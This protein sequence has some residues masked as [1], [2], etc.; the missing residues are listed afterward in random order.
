MLTSFKVAEEARKRWLQI[1]R[2]QKWIEELSKDKKRTPI[3]TVWLRILCLESGNIVREEDS[4][5]LVTASTLL[6]QAL[7]NITRE[8]YQLPEELPETTDERYKFTIVKI[9]DVDNRH[10]V[11]EE[12]DCESYSAFQTQVGNSYQK[13]RRG[14]YA[15]IQV[16]ITERK[17]Q[18]E[19][20]MEF[21]PMCQTGTASVTVV[22]FNT[23]TN[24]LNT[25]SHME[26]V[27][28][29]CPEEEAYLHELRAIFATLP[30]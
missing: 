6:G 14:G 18:K 2:V 9:T 20:F 13:S 25:K 19:Y 4:E 29:N 17:S 15:K 22:M 12:K 24:R 11:M 16:R 1:P 8:D 7:R 26:W 5:R 10:L 27:R 28:K 3:H 23:I 21:Q 30:N